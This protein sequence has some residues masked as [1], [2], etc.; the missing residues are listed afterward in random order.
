[1]A[2]GGFD[3]PMSQQPDQVQEAQEM[4]EAKRKKRNCC[5]VFVGIIIALA[6]ALVLIIVIPLGRTGWEI[7]H[8]QRTEYHCLDHHCFWTGDKCDTG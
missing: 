4:I 2:E 3:T 1:M 5:A 7:C 8:A 6:T